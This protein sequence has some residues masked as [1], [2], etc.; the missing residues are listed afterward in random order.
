[1]VAVV[2]KE[3]SAISLRK[4]TYGSDFRYAGGGGGWD[5]VGGDRSDWRRGGDRTQGIVGP[6]G[7]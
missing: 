4:T 1:P 7:L 6:D 5:I 3:A 2:S